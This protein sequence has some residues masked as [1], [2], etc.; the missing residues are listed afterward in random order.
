V[1]GAL[2]RTVTPGGSWASPLAPNAANVPNAAVAHH[3]REIEPG[4]RSDTAVTT[5]GSTLPKSMRRGQMPSLRVSSASADGIELA[6]PLLEA[7]R[8]LSKLRR[9][10]VVALLALG[11]GCDSTVVVGKH[12][13]ATPPADA[14]PDADM[15][16]PI[17]LPWS[18]GFEDGWCE[19]AQPHGFCFG[20]GGGSYTLV[21][22]PVH[23]GQFAAAFT[24]QSDSDSGSQVRCVAQGTFPAA[25]Y[26]SAWYYVPPPAPQNTGLWNLFHFQG[27]STLD[28][29]VDTSLWDVSLLELDGGLHSIVYDFVTKMATDGTTVPPIPIGQ[30]FHVEVYFKRAADNTGEITMWQDGHLAVDYTGVQ[31]DATTWGQWYVGN[32][33]TALTPPTSTVY[34]DDV[35]IS[36]TP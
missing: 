33:A 5:K 19:Y 32:L 4:L 22:S 1:A 28:S 23:K 13:C 27:A 11:T 3:R 7:S 30:W 8:M 25:A 2:Q 34:V 18:T 36:A 21:T 31:T 24:V 17:A 20:T 29:G 35:T 10:P 14:V 16:A 15:T 12:F 9:S 6:S 26:Y